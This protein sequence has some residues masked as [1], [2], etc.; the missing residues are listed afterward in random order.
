MQKKKSF[1][2]IA[3][4]TIYRMS[5]KETGKEPDNLFQQWSSGTE[6]DGFYLLYCNVTL[7]IM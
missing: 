7:L 6:T 3:I 1:V 5:T 4:I 2:P